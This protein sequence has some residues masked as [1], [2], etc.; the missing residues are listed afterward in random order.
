MNQRNQRFSVGQLVTDRDGFL[1]SIVSVLLH[2]MSVTG[3]EHC[4]GASAQYFTRPVGPVVPDM[5]YSVRWDWQLSLF[6]N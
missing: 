4:I 1:L 5:D 3:F 6:L 2:P